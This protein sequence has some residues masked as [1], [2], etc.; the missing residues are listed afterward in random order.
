MAGRNYAPLMGG[1]FLL[2]GL[3]SIVSAD[4][5]TTGV[6]L[7]LGLAF[8]IAEDGI[9]FGRTAAAE[10]TGFRWTPRNGVAVGLSL[11]AVGLV[12]VDVTRAFTD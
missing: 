6:W 2:A 8:L 11:V 9:R 5:P 10:A 1:I 12:A 3:V 7:S 4:W